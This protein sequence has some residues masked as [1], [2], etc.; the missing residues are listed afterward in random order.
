MISNNHV[1]PFIDASHTSPQKL[2]IF[3]SYSRM[4]KSFK[5]KLVSRLRND[6]H[7]RY[8][9]RYEI[10]IDTENL[11]GGQEWVEEIKRAIDRCD[12]FIFIASRTSVKSPYCQYEARLARSEG[13]KIIPVKV[14]QRSG[15]P[16]LYHQINETNLPDQ[17]AWMSG[18]NFIHMTEGFSDVGFDEIIAAIEEKGSSTPISENIETPRV[19]HVP[20]WKDD[21]WRLWIR[22]RE[23]LWIPIVIAFIVLA[24]ILAK[25]FTP[26]PPPYCTITSFQV[27]PAG[28]SIFPAKGTLTAKS[29]DVLLIQAVVTGCIL[30]PK[31]YHW[32]TLEG[33]F[34]PA[35]D[36]SIAYVV[37]ANDSDEITFTLPPNEGDEQVKLA[38]QITDRS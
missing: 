25:N 16:W 10:W 8:K 5:S 23:W 18:V 35:P 26:L 37:P 19:P 28:G 7:P 20:Q 33:R 12:R 2:K 17:I 29:G 21:L 34:T 9:N 36:G 6:P 13:K 3:I 27:T 15:I 31:Q 22:I 38:I 32:Q 14:R 11:R 1:S 4:D 30:S 24:V